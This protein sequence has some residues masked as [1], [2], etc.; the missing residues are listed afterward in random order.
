MPPSKSQKGA[1]LELGLSNLTLFLS[2]GE[3]QLA[4]PVVDED[5]VDRILTRLGGRR[6]AFLQLKARTGP[7][8]GGILRLAFAPIANA[9]GRETLYLVAGELLPR[10]PW[11]GPRVAVIPASLLPKPNA[12]GQVELAIPL[13]KGSRSR[14]APFVH[15]RVDLATVLSGLLDGGPAYPF[16]PAGG[17]EVLVKRL[18]PRARGHIVEMELAAAVLFRGGERMNWWPALVDDYGE[19]F[20]LTDPERLAALRVQPKG[21]FELDSQGRLH[22]K[23]PRG[24]FRPRT[25]DYLV[26]AHYRADLP[27]LDEWAYVMRS[28]EFAK[29]ARAYGKFLEIRAR[30]DPASKDMWRPWLYRVEEIAGVFETALAV[31]RAQG[32]AARL[33]ARGDEVEA[34]RRALRPGGQRIDRL[35]ARK[36]AAIG[37]EAAQKAGSKARRAGLAGGARANSR[38]RRR[39]RRPARP[40]RHL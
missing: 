10:S 38:A 34:A 8:K 22:L 20:A 15:D 26:F 4:R 33:P 40:R 37:A 3:L 31:R 18:S 13:R 9:A 28:D 39:P 16:P 32:A 7:I 19:D 30:P 17:P 2:G 27:A 12:S 35:V 24:T 25:F 21:A 14:W 29:R 23:V 1:I 36:P 11:V 6:A 5:D